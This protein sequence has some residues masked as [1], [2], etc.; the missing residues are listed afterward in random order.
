MLQHRFVVTYTKEAK[1]KDKIFTTYEEGK[2][3]YDRRVQYGEKAIL[4]KVHKVYWWE[5]LLNTEFKWFGL[6]LPL[7]PMLIGAGIAMEIW[8]LKYMG[9]FQ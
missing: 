3:F 9:V 4:C 1:T 6:K 8:H 2:K 7:F 5:N